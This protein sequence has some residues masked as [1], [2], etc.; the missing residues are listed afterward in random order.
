M[1]NIIVGDMVELGLEDGKIMVLRVGARCFGHILVGDEVIQMG[2]Q[3]SLKEGGRRL[4]S[5]GDIFE[6]RRS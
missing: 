2:L 4:V 1:Q 3:P 6:V 5:E